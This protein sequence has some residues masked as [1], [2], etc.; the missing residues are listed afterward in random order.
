MTFCNYMYHHQQT[1]DTQKMVRS[2]ETKM[3]LIWA[4]KRHMYENLQLNSIN[5]DDKEMIS[6]HMTL[7]AQSNFIYIFY[8]FYIFYMCILDGKTC[9]WKK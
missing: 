7:S 9:S 5:R 4:T 2:E 6:I 8:S 3:K 1:A